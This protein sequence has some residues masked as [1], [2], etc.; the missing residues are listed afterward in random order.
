MLDRGKRV[1]EFIAIQRRDNQ[2]WAIPGV[3]L[4]ILLY[5]KVCLKIYFRKNNMV[6]IMISKNESNF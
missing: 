3:S 5:H 1:L 2:Q 4:H 6:L